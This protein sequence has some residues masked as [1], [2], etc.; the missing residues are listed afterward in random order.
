MGEQCELPLAPRAGLGYQRRSLGL[1]L[2]L[3]LSKLHR[4]E[5]H[6]RPLLPPHAIDLDRLDLDGLVCVR[7]VLRRLRALNERIAFKILGGNCARIRCVY[8][9]NAQRIFTR[10]FVDVHIFP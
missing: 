2:T 8:I 4:V 7:V 10:V 5:R 9:R 6:N 3:A 1:P